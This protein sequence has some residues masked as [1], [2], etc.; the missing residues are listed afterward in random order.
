M[1]D[2][3]LPMASARRGGSRLRWSEA[4]EVGSL[5]RPFAGQPEW[6]RLH[7]G[8][9]PLPVHFFIVPSGITLERAASLAPDVDWRDFRRGK[10]VWIVQTFLR[11]REAGLPVTM[12]S[13]VPKRGV[14]VFHKEEQRLVLERMPVGATPVLV[15]VRG[16]FRSADAADFEVLQNGRFS[17]G[18][19]CFF[20]PHWPQPG[21]IPRD[22]ARGTRVER[23]A[24]KGY[25]GNLA[26]ELRGAE[27]RDF[28]DRHELTLTEDAVVDDAWSHPIECDWHDYREVDVALAL[29]PPARNGNTHKPASKLSNAWLAGVPA[30]LGPEYAYHELRRSPLDYLEVKS[31]RDAQAA[32]LRLKHDP[33]LYRRMV[34]NGRQRARDFSVGS[35]TSAWIEFLFATV[36]CLAARR[37]EWHY[38]P[39]PRGARAWARKAARVLRGAPRK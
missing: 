36:P 33:D 18:R 23:I 6:R 20:V 28:L 14:V 10:E 34:R 32:I 31:V 24:F 1:A 8:A 9:R 16:D 19:R 21:L 38:A 4:A 35:V 39:T 11:L 25:I 22:S 15:S 30:V 3:L 29:R 5:R 13:D 26:S 7:A 2:A 27:F 12:G 37:P 17:D